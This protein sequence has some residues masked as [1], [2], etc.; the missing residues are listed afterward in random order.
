MYLM[1]II[2]NKRET[3][4]KILEMF[5]K[6]G[7]GGATVLDSRGM[8]QTFM[9]CESPVVGGLRAMIY[10]QCRPGNNTIISIVET[11]EKYDQA[12]EEAEKITGSFDEPGTGLAC[13]FPL[14]RIKGFPNNNNKKL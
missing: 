5:L 8:G 11:L 9:A 12:V 14:A 7:I 6:I 13:V 2:V 4:N 3:V 10:D 1:L